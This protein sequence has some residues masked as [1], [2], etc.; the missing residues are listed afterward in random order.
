MEPVYEC[1]DDQPTFRWLIVV[2]GIM[3]IALAVFMPFEG[4]ENP[5]FIWGLKIFLVLMAMVVFVATPVVRIRAFPEYI[6]VKYGITNWITFKLDRSKITAINAIEYN[7]MK[8]FGGWGIKDGTGKW[9]GWTAFTASPTNKALTIETTEK[10]Y[11][12][13]C[14]NPEEA[15]TILRNLMGMK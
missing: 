9:K 14:N 15:E 5:Y 10:N 7:A 13:G 2:C 8:E 12:I 4:D 1:K 11:L 6:E 3:F